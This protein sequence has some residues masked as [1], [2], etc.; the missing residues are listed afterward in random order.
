[1][2]DLRIFYVPAGIRNSLLPNTS[3]MCYLHAKVYCF[4]LLNIQFDSGV[5]NPSPASPQLDSRAAPLLAQA[6]VLPNL[7]TEANKNII[8]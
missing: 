7:I 4:Y 3:L 2:N 6:N 8:K 1:M 5:D